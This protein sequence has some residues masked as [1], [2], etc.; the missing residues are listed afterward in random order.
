MKTLYY[1]LFI[2]LFTGQSCSKLVEVDP[3]ITKLTAGNAYTNDANAISVVSSLYASLSNYSFGRPGG[4]GSLSALGSLY[5]DELGFVHL[6]GNG[7][8]VYDGFYSNKLSSTTYGAEYWEGAYTDIYN[9]NAALNGIAESHTLTPVVKKQ[10][11]SELKFLR[12]LYY[13]FIVNL[14]GDVPW[15]TTTDYTVNARVS[16]TAALQVLKNIQADLR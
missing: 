14:Y 2:V 13:Y 11:L 15:V 4:I 8:S 7:T 5:T 6:P 12:S 16:R 1:C 3:P 9:C 10:L